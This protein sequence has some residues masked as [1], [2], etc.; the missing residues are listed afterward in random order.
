M[1]HELF[2]TSAPRGLQPGSNGFCTVAE[3]RGLSPLLRERLEDLSGYRPLFPPNDPRAVQNP[4][5][6]SHLKL[7]V[8]GKTLSVLSRVCASGLDHTGRSNKFAHHVVL[9]GREQP[10]GGPAWLLEQPGFVEAAWDGKVRTLAGGRAPRPGDRPPAPC[11]H[12]QERAGDAGWAGVLAESFLR[13]PSRPAYLLYPAG[14]DPL[15]LLAEALA[16]LTPDRRWQVTF[17]TYF[18]SLPPGV[19][20]AWR[21]VPLEAPEAAEA[22]HAPGALVL[23]LDRPLGPAP[24]GPLTDAARTGRAPASLPAAAATSLP[25]AP[26]PRYAAPPPPDMPAMPTG[27]QPAPVQLLEPDPESA[28]ELPPQPEPPAPAPAAA[29]WSWGWGFCTGVVS[30]I[31][32]LLLVGVAAYLAAPNLFASL[33]P[34]N[35]S[36]GGEQGK[37]DDPK[38]GT[39]DKGTRDGK[40]PPHHDKDAIPKA[41]HDRAMARAGEELKKANEARADTEKERN[42]A[43]AAK[44][45]AEEGVKA[46]YDRG[47]KEGESKQHADLEKTRREVKGLLGGLKEVFPEFNPKVDSGVLEKPEEIAKDVRRQFAFA[48]EKELTYVKDLN[49]YR[50]QGKDYAGRLERDLLTTEEF[51]AKQDII[52]NPVATTAAKED[53][54]KAIERD[55]EATKFVKEQSAFCKKIADLSQVPSTQDSAR[56][57]QRWYDD[58][59]KQAEGKKIKIPPP[60]ER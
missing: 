37:N 13:D 7:T 19:S 10:A 55:K 52:S 12:W 16:L 57:L 51:K 38:G 44:K 35:T 4:V 56:A 15:P 50:Q 45:R 9:E 53:A 47:F 31:A 30:G 8:S 26:A 29:G 18:T 46:E 14:L 49:K 20:C 25:R 27:P 43:L 17:S 33:A 42:E 22:A 40:G 54:K 23:R 28:A 11:R 48:A 2:Y 60:P 39:E 41:E 3:T 21:C 24:A 58:I 34:G 59:L 6:S 36:N 1:S 32:V 5:A